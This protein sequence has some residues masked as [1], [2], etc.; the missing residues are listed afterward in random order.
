MDADDAVFFTTVYDWVDFVMRKELD[1]P[2]SR[3][4]MVI[5]LDLNDDMVPSVVK[6][7]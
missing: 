3:G 1:K 6:Y 4:R 7:C 5:T 2:R